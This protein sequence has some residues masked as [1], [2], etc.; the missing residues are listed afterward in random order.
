[1]TANSQPDGPI[2]P[3]LTGRSVRAM[4]DRALWIARTMN[5][6]I[7]ADSDLVLIDAGSPSPFLNS[8]FLLPLES[9]DDR[10]WELARR[11]MTFM[12]SG[13]AK[14]F[15]LWA[16]A[17]T[18][19]LSSLGFAPSGLPPLMHRPPADGGGT[20]PAEL[21]IVEVADLEELETFAATM[22]VAYPDEALIPYERGS[23]VDERVLGGDFRLW[24][25]RV[26]GVAVAT[27]GAMRSQGL[28]WVEFIA[29]LPEARGKGYGEAMTWAATLAWPELPAALV[30]SDAGRPVYERMG[31]SLVSR[32]S[33][34]TGH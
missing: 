3:E 6:R 24:I 34:W 19:D 5:Q 1:M 17:A 14:P 10:D 18:P 30:A 22:V 2:D 21:E 20:S 32:W 7:E 27:A 23:M 13:S 29:T 8:A 16:G 28:A 15:F 25:G 11:A 26:D 33:L 9:D 4:A 31:Y 12:R